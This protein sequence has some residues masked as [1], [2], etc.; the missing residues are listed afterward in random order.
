MGHVAYY[1]KGASNGESLKVF[2]LAKFPETLKKKITL[3]F[4]FKQTL[5][6][7]TPESIQ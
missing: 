6:G 7:T 4:H 2:A 1:E 5:D 3:L